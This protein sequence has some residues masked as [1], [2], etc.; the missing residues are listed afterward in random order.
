MVGLKSVEHFQLKSS[1][2][3]C[4]CF[5]CWQRKWSLVKNGS[6]HMEEG[7]KPWY[8]L[9]HTHFKQSRKVQIYWRIVILFLYIYSLGVNP[10]AWSISFPDNQLRHQRQHIISTEDQPPY[11]V[12]FDF[13]KAS[14][15]IRRLIRSLCAE[16]FNLLPMCEIKASS[17]IQSSNQNFS[18]ESMATTEFLLHVDRLRGRW[19]DF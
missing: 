1:W 5:Q 6:K 18:R 13:I 12:T 16:S 15:R 9:S 4:Q 2:Q 3:R 14:S 19:V 8:S 17:R 11:Q 10:S 7:F